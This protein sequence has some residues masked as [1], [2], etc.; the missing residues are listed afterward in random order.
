MKCQ[1]QSNDIFVG[2]V[3]NVPVRITAINELTQAVTVDTI[4]PGTI[5]G[6]T[7][8]TVSTLNA[9]QLVS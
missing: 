3:V 2:Q 1:K 4:Y 5:G 7:P 9:K 8:T 6:T